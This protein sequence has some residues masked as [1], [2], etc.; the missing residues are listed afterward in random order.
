MHGYQKERERAR[1]P[2]HIC[3]NKKRQRK[4]GNI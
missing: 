2:L 1:L 4:M 3:K